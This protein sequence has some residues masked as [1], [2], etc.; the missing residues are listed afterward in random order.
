VDKKQEMGRGYKIVWLL[1]SSN[2][3]KSKP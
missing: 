1:S 3:W 2:G